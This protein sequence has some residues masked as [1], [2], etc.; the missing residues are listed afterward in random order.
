MPLPEDPGLAW[1]P[2]SL[3]PLYDQIAVHDA[4][5]A[6]D[7][8]RLHEVY[9]QGTLTERWHTPS[10]RR[11]NQTPTQ[12]ASMFWARNT[13]SGRVRLHVPAAADIATT[14]ADLLFAEPP[15]LLIPAA[16][17]QKA[18]GDAKLLQDRLAEIVD[19]NG[20]INVLLEAAE[21][22]GALGGVYL[23]ATWDRDLADV[24]LLTVEH[25]DRVVPEFAYG[26]FLRAATIWREVGRDGMTVWRHLE[27]HEPGVILHGLYEGTAE[28]LGRKVEL[29][30]H[31]ATADLSVSEGDAVDTGIDGLTVG[32]VPNM[33]PNRRMRRD[34]HGRSDLDGVETLLDALD[35][36]YSSWLRD[37]RLGKARVA[38]PQGAMTNHG[39]G[40][41][42]SFDDDREVFTE[43][44]LLQMDG[45]KGQLTPIEFKLRTEEHAETA[46]DLFSK[47]VTTAGYSGRSFGLHDG[48]TGAVTA[49]EVHA[50]ERRSF[51]TRGKK[52]GYWKPELA[53]IATVLLQLD[54]VHFAGKV[55]EDVQVEWPDGV[56]ENPK[57]QAETLDLLHR[58][59]AVSIDTKVRMLHPEWDE[60]RVTA[61]VQAIQAE[62]G[63]AVP[64][65]M[66]AGD[67]P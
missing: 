34:A 6:G 9:S 67:I 45:S 48:G 64:D 10:R 38:V 33:R 1:P 8:K 52:V 3:G 20:L 11:R 37:I 43:L 53:R 66:Q 16:H 44:S 12:R 31:P 65:P 5:W 26:R 28:K 40:Q 55:P 47:I 49:T 51:V 39:A 15:Q 13:V 41:G 54:R 7:P 42:A 61:E 14:S 62:A 60:D 58:A 19:V 24:P 50:S 21:I 32:Y 25:A 29:A 46:R 35:E 57:H 4:W 59:E 17:E 2:K 27:R 22:G 18:E 30:A 56:E 63:V 23:R 36:T